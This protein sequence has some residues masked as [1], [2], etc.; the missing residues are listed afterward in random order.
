M[1]MRGHGGK[2][3][4]RGGAVAG[5]AAVLRSDVTVLQRDRAGVAAGAEAGVS[6]SGIASIFVVSEE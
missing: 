3:A 1:P 4:V 6:I 2:A 5:R